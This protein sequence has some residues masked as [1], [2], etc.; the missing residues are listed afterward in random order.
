MSNEESKV[1]RNALQENL[2]NKGKNAY[3]FAHDKTA[4]GPTWD[5]KP[6]PRLLAK[7]SSSGTTSNILEGAHAH[8]TNDE[9]QN[10]LQGLQESKSSFDFRKSNISKYAFL[11]ER[12]KVKI[13][14]DLEG[15]G[16][17]CESEDAI[18]LDWDER[19]FSLVIRFDSDIKCLSFGRLQGTIEKA[20]FK[21]K[22]DRI[23]IILTKKVP[24]GEDPKEWTSIGA[25]ADTD[26]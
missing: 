19:S 11:D 1:S 22:T 9:A 26:I 25:M 3:Y 23:V 18:T 10:L 12:K 14:I 24:E 13:Y 16:D 4:T 15:V 2:E 7:H 21:K 5:G 8:I 6:Q 17:I 20:I